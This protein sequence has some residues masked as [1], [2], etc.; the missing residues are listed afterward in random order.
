MI[1]EQINIIFWGV[2]ACKNQ[3]KIL[4]KKSWVIFGLE[5]IGTFLQ[6]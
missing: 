6:Q 5:I 3:L 1:E 2:V 4:S